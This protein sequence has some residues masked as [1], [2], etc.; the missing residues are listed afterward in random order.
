MAL[1]FLA[2][3]TAGSLAQ[4]ASPPKGSPLRAAL[5]DAL[6]PMVE[7][8]V[9]KPVEFVVDNMR[10][11]GEWAF[12]V[13]TPQRPGGGDIEYAYT[14][15]QTQWEDGAFDDQAIALLRDTPRGWLVYGYTLGATDASYIGWKDRFPVPPEVFP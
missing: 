14:Q 2:A 6:R 3:A 7:A 13:V 5:L 11:L 12:V 9:G 4:V 1:G 10:V 8:E 15:Y